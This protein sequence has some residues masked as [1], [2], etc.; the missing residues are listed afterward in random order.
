MYAKYSQY[1]NVGEVFGLTRREQ[2]RD[3]VMRLR[4]RED[5]MLLVSY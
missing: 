1:E 4:D 2:L 3:H 5:Y